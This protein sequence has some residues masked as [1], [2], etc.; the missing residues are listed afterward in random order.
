M[1]KKR[2]QNEGS[3][4]KRKNGLWTAQITLQGN[5]SLEMG[6][7]AHKCAEVNR[8]LKNEKQ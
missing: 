5:L 8:T 7:T 4:F 3:I 1:A 6:E 2:G